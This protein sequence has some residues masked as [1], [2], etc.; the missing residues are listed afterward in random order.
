M[1]QGN[2]NTPKTNFNSIHNHTEYSL[3]DGAV[4]VD[5]L[6]NRTKKNNMSAVA[7]TD[8]GVLYGIMEFYKKAKKA[9]VKPL[10]GCEVYVAPHDRF[11]KKSQKRYH[12][13]LIA[14]NNKGFRNLMRIVSKS[15]LEGFY[16]KPRVDKDLLYNNREGLISLSAC[17]QGE[18]PQLL[19]EDDIKGAK[20]A[21]KEYQSIFGRENFFIELQDHN[22]AQEKRANSK[23][24]QLANKMDLPLVVT[25]DTHYLNK[26]DAD[27]HDI[28]L[29][30][31]T[32]TNINDEDRM[33]FTGNEFYFKSK[34]E[35]RKLFPEI[36]SAYKNTVKIAERCEVD[37]DF[38]QF[39]LP[40]YPGADNKEPEE[41][42]RE[43]CE[44]GLE[45]KSLEHSKEARER[46]EYELSIIKEMGYISYF[47]IVWDFIDYANKEGIRVGPGR[48]SAAGSLVSY[49]LGITKIDPLKY[50]LIF[51]RFLNPERVTMPDIDIDFDERRDE[52]IDY[53]KRR[54]GKERVAQI[55][56][57]GTMAA[58]AA[59]RDV[60]RAL[61]LP[62]GKVDRIA[63]MIP[64]SHGIT[65]DKALEKSEKLK[66]E[67]EKDKEIAKLM[68]YARGLEGMPRHISTHA[69]GVIIGPEDLMNLVPLQLQD[70]SVIT[71]LPMDELE[72]MGLLKMDFLGLRNLTVI[73]NTLNLIEKRY[74][75]KINIENIPLDDSDVYEMLSTGETLG[76]FQMESYLFRNLNQRLKPDNF[77][78]I[79]ALLALGRPGPL[80]SGLVDDFIKGR[81]GEKEVEYLHPKLEPILKDTFGLILYQEQVM[82]I[83]SELAGYT[84]GEADLLR[85]GMGKKKKELISREREKFVKGAKENNI[86]KKTANEIFDQVEYF[87][88]YGFNKSHSAA[89]ALV[90]Y[91]TAYLKVKYPAEFMSAL[92]SSVMGN[93]DKVAQYIDEAKNIGL[94]VLAPDVNESYNDFTPISENS[95][96]FGLKVIKNLGKKAIKAIISNRQKEKYKNFVDFFK[97]VDLSQFS[98]NMI[99][100]LIKAGAFD[101]FEEVNRSQ[102]LIKYEELYNRYTKMQ[103]G[104]N[105]GQRS[106]FDITEDESFYEDNIDYPDVNHLRTGDKLS[107]EK[108]Y[109]GIYLTGHPLDP[110]RKKINLLTNFTTKYLDDKNDLRYFKAN[111]AG[112]ILEKKNHVTKRKNQ[113]AFLTIEDF[114][115]KLS[116]VVFPDL[117]SEL[118]NSI[119]KGESVFING[120]FKDGDSLIANEI[121]ALEKDYL[122]INLNKAKINKK[123]L[124]KLKYYFSKIE[125]KSP[126][127]IKIGDK[128]ILVDKNYYVDLGNN[129][130]IEKLNEE[131]SK[132]VYKIL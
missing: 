125:G 19:L 22:I 104:R 122:F 13:I 129:K 64:Y 61:D 27:M 42:L 85:R 66:K 23:L 93:L 102:M 11:T 49:L 38:S 126:V 110:Y 92:L 120:Y 57:F 29:A 6:I 90:A 116:V 40:A 32:G 17:I 83:A 25:N 45:E 9:G 73:E 121:I 87:A 8:H 113:M 59:V 41:I 24:I 20:K 68:K 36:G 50:G 58:R 72:D 132:K 47:L 127:F 21:V 131:L 33:T 123:K 2:L 60:G 67:V 107:W 112:L 51:E 1:M 16:Y 128:I 69:A 18:V 91:Q 95:I 124:G 103:K 88:G 108:E 77:S 3:L 46:L 52:I 14:Q 12:L 118:N 54:Y 117:Y 105:N 55:G 44:K 81:H 74:N 130:F 37:F 96:R 43:K 28:L 56:T 71:Q 34:K 89:Y 98:I 94:K 5:D 86:D 26:E 99:E 30:L 78:D 97:K 7:M 114:Y 100:A 79:I 80:N 101:S 35:M 39:H 48:G 31:K 62:Y 76:V 115:G 4:R 111:T 75:K 63:K 109:L 15:W 82:E 10:L 53:V 84:M 65:L 106:F 119:E 70:E